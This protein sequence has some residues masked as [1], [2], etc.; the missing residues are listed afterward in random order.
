LTADDQETPGQGAA[1]TS[2]PTQISSTTAYL[3]IFH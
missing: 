2:I 1:P 3:P